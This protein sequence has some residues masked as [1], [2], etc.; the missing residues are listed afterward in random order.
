MK[1]IYIVYGCKADP[2]CGVSSPIY[3]ASSL[4][5]AE[6]YLERILDSEN[7]EAED[8]LNGNN[9]DYFSGVGVFGKNI[10]DAHENDV[11]GS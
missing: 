4:E 1:D 9:K 8:F 11:M 7:K 10:K 2:E 5:A 3:F 6:S